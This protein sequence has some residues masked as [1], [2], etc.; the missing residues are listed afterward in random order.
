MRRAAVAALAALVLARAAA[1]ANGRFPAT[2]SITTRPGE[3]RPFWLGATFGLLVSPD[4]GATLSWI[5]E[6]AIGYA[7]TYD[8]VYAVTGAG[9]LLAAIY[10]GL[11]VSRDGGCTW[12]L[13]GGAL[14]GRWIADVR[15]AS[16]GAIFAATKSSAGDNDVFVSRDDGRTWASTGAL[17]PGAFWQTLRVAP[18]DPL[19]VYVSGYA[20]AS[21]GDAPAEPGPMLLRSDDG[22]ASWLDIPVVVPGTNVLRLLGVSRLDP[23]RVFMVVPSAPSQSVLRSDDGGVALE[24]VDSVEGEVTAFESIVGDG[25]ETF[26]VGARATA[27]ALRRSTDGGTT[28]SACPTEPVVGC[29]GARDDGTLLACGSNFAPDEMALGRSSDRCDSFAG[30][31]R[32]T[33]IDGPLE[34]P[35]GTPQA[36]LCAPMWPSVCASVGA[37]ASPADAS[38]G[39]PSDG[40]GGDGCGCASPGSSRGE[41]GPALLLVLLAVARRRGRPGRPRRRSDPGAW[42]P[43]GGPT[44]PR[45]RRG[46]SARSRR[47]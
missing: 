4:D 7:G 41:A 8:P 37:C 10:D 27:G 33:D 25:G 18:S 31:L 20:L 44:T 26:F 45:G 21:V 16:D 17:R 3:P 2:T 42:T 9:T 40:G 11:R 38:G 34:C 19:R 23:D 28:W 22:G 46:S 36:T 35:A 5:C 14:D 6:G 43:A 47:P 15:V 30:A 13:A 24:L 29:L 1:R 12:D 39:E 32:F